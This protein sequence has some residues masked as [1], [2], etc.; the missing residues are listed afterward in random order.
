MNPYNSHTHCRVAPADPQ[1]QNLAKSV[2]VPTHNRQT[3]RTNKE[4][5]THNSGLA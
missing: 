3:I 2:S 1:S 5:R 4:H